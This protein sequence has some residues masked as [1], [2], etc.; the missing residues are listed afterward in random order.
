MPLTTYQSGK[1]TVSKHYLSTFQVLRHLFKPTSCTRCHFI[2]IYK[3]E[4]WGPERASNRAKV[5]QPVSV[6]ARYWIWPQNPPSCFYSQCLYLFRSSI[7]LIITLCCSS[8]NFNRKQLSIV[9][10]HKSKLSCFF[11]SSLPFHWVKYLLSYWLS[12]LPTLS[13]SLGPLGVPPPATKRLI[14]DIFLTAVIYCLLQTSADG[15]Q[16]EW[17]LIP[18]EYN[19]QAPGGTQEEMGLDIS[20]SQQQPCEIRPRRE[21]LP[22]WQLSALHLQVPA[23]SCHRRDYRGHC[24]CGTFGVGDNF[25]GLR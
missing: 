18:L 7:F 3:Q 4:T 5:I 16:R 14:P 19:N 12:P 11:F 17:L 9:Q 13:T 15:V 6:G 1:F 21:H 23:L 20:Q 2:P 24:K 25:D 10:L 8:I 22:Q